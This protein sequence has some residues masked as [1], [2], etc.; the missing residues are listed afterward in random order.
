MTIK[1][2]TDFYKPPTKAEQEFSYSGKSPVMTFEAFD[3]CVISW[4]RNKYG[5]RFGKALWRDEMVDLEMLDLEDELDQ[6]TF[7]AYCNQV[8]EVLQI[9]LPK[10]AES[11]VVTPKFKTCK[12]QMEMEKFRER[13]F[14]FCGKNRVWRSTK[15]A[16]E[17]RSS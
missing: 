8:Y 10:W 14:L 7:D 17:E 12:F 4:A 6:F 9:D 3:E 13:L 15:A 5:E 16:S 11:L 1:G 2:R